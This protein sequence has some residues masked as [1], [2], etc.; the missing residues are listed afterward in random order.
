[1]KNWLKNIKLITWDLDGTLYPANPD[2]SKEIEKR[3][4]EKVAAY[5]N[6]SINEAKIEFN[7]ILTETKS[8]TKTLD[9]IG[10]DGTQFF[11]DM[12][13]DISLNLYI[14]KNPELVDLFSKIQIPKAML[15][16]SNSRES[17]KKKLNLIGLKTDQFK[18][19][20][21]SVDVG[22]NKPHPKI[23]KALI[24]KA[25]TLSHSPILPGEILYV[26][27][28]EKLDIIPPKKLGIKTCL[29]GKTS[30][31]ADICVQNPLELCTMLLNNK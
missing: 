23:F 8:H 22:Y 27:D 5:L 20:I 15:T 21:T 4:I 28:R 16:N 30:N 29:V 11:L 1:M 6:T 9:K 17:I 24:E 10:I 18:F 3:K 12:W 7:K 26:G 14:Q 25:Q 31:E 19:I 2:F 13:R